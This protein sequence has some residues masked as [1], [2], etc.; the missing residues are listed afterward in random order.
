MCFD[1]GLDDSHFQDVLDNMTE[2]EI[3]TAVEVNNQRNDEYRRAGLLP[4]QSELPLD[5]TVE[6]VQMELIEHNT[7]P[8]SAVETDVTDTYDIEGA[9][10]RGRRARPVNA[11]TR[12][13][14]DAS[15]TA[16]FTNPRPVTVT[17]T[18]SAASSTAP[19]TPVPAA[20]APAS[21]TPIASAT[22]QAPAVVSTEPPEASS[23]AQPP[24]EEQGSNSV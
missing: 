24:S 23:A 1:T 8:Y 16:G 19:A 7:R 4:P 12:N 2:E 18:T 22:V 13:D 10:V 21:P 3:Q 11:V 6:E 5:L 9:P 14:V 20:A 17:S 15:T